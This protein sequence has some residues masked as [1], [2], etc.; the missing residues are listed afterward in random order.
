[1]WPFWYMAV[2]DVH[3][4]RWCVHGNAIFHTR[5]LYTMSRQISAVADEPARRCANAHRVIHKDGSSS[6]RQSP[7]EQQLRRS[8]FL[9]CSEF[10]TKLSQYLL[11]RFSRFFRQMEGICVN[12]LDP[13]Q[14]VRF[15]K[16]VA[17]AT[18]FVSYRTFSFWAEV[19][20]ERFSQSLQHMVVLN[21]RWSVQPSFSDILR[22][23][24]MAT[25]SGKIVARLPTPAFIALSFRN[26]MG[27]RYHNERINN[28]DDAF[29]LR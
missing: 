22:D 10:Q 25:N 21:C 7:F 28:V 18:N 3:R 13:V 8:K 9:L 4:C 1:M 20:Q 12:F 17:M 19:S 23:V 2:L 27:Y 5:R 29:V 24:I 26:G 6:Y 11:D 15:F 14:F 16:E